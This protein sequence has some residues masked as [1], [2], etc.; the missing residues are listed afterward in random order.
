MI[1]VSM[2]CN[3]APNVF[4]RLYCT[5]SMELVLIQKFLI[6]IALGAL[7]GTE[8]EMSKSHSGEKVAGVRTFSLITLL[9]TTLA[10]LS[11]EYPYLVVVGAGIFGLLVIAGYW[12]IGAADPGITTEVGSIVAF[13]IGVLCYSDPSLAV[14]LAIF[15]GIIF[16]VKKK[17]HSLIKKMREEEL[18]DTLKFALIAFVILP[19]LPNEPIDPFGV[20]NPYKIWLLV[21]FIS[22]IG[23]VGYFL[24]RIF[25]TKSGTGL[26][27]VLGG[28]ASSTAVTASMSHRSRESADILFPALFATVIANTIMFLRILV[29]VFVVR[30]VLVG[31]LLIPM[32]AMMVT[33]LVVAVYFWNKKVPSEVDVDLQDPF[34]LTPALKFGLFFAFILVISKVASQYLGE[35]GV[36]VTGIISGLADVDAITLSMATLAGKE[37]S[38]EVAVTTIILAA[39]SN[40]VAK[41]A[42]TVLFGSPEFKKRMILTSA[43]IMTVGLLVILL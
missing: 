31:D 34:T 16:V 21:V 40:I 30:R 5:E 37:V 2:F 6:S 13:V 17:S 43:G 23:Y 20:L 38:T 11:Q 42:I 32:A 28:L 18:I 19:F 4:K 27:G 25:G 10:H 1:A 26:T 14:M 24:I 36:Y 35:P 41:T 8:R 33:G 7:L 39:I 9:G 15:V 29:E 3:I 22:G 12:K